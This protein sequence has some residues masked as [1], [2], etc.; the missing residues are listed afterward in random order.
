MNN[1]FYLLIPLFLAATLQAGGAASASPQPTVG[2]EAPL[3]NKEIIKL[4]SLDLGNEVVIAKI[5]QA[6][7]VAF[8]LDT[9]NLILLKK[10]GVAKEVIAAMLKR[11]TPE[12]PVVSAAPANVQGVVS[13][14][15]SEGEIK[16]LKMSGSAGVDWTLTRTV[17]EFIGDKS[18]ARTRDGAAVLELCSDANPQGTYFLVK[19]DVSSRK[20]TRSMNMGGGLMG[21]KN[22]N[23]PSKGNLLEF[24][25]NQG[26]P[27]QWTL[28]PKQPLKPGEYGL[29]MAVSSM[30]NT[31]EIFD[32]GVDE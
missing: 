26:Q 28:K 29:Y 25:V 16:L 31:G 12:K 24:E 5:N 23:S 1:T 20:H 17:L 8:Q 30:V 32:F 10:S 7:A 3:T 6:K 9:D 21:L 11:A 15:T 22:M 2:Q 14:K 4:C 27:G 13:L 18:K 19:C